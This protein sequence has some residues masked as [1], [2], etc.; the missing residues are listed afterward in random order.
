MKY[1]A[2]RK[3]TLFTY[4]LFCILGVNELFSQETIQITQKKDSLFFSV[5]NKLILKASVS[6]NASKLQ[7]RE[8]HYVLNNAVYQTISL[9]PMDFKRFTFKANITAEEGSIA[10]EGERWNDGISIVRHTVGKSFNLLNNSV[11]NRDQDWLLSFDAAY[12][13]MKLQPLENDQYQI[14]ME[15]SELIIRFK[16]KY[17]QQHRGLAYFKPKEYQIWKKPVVGWC[18][19]FAYFDNVTETDMHRTAD[20][21]STKLKKYGLDYI[22]IDDG[23]QQV[24]IGMPDTWINANKKFPAGMGNLANYIASKGFKPGIWTNVSFADSA[25]AYQHKELFIKTSKNEIALGNWVGYVMNGANKATIDQ[26]IK[27]VYAEFNNEGWQYFK[28]DALR[29]LKYEGYN[30]FSKD[31]I[32][33]GINKNEA[34]R[35]VVK[36]VRNQIGKEKFLMACWGIRPELVGLVDGCRIG[37]DGYSYAGLAQFN[38]YNNI[39]WR[40]DPDHIVLSAKEAYRSCTA[41]SLTGSLFML[42]DKPELYEK[43]NLIDAAIRSIPVLITRPGQVYDIDPSRSSLITQVET[44][45]SGSGPRPFDASS[46]TTTDLFQMDINKPYENWTILGRLDERDRVIPLKDLGLDTKKEYLVFE[47]WSKEFKGIQIKQFVPG[48]IDS[49]FNC[50]VF[51]FREKQNHPQL[52]ATNRHISCGALELKQLQWTNNRLTGSSD[53]VE[54]DLYTIYVYEPDGAQFK[55]IKTGSAQLIENNKSGNIRKISF[56]STEAAAIQWAIYYQ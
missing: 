13:A 35:N 49:A 40:N 19:W 25:A 23:Y 54:N 29:H 37:N 50:Q 43:S 7:I 14:Q 46:T 27:P 9:V 17:Y 30:A 32:R 39:I 3:T 24:P 26:L 10:C 38:S 15:K 52:L 33:D 22:Q 12:P 48:A 28:L 4:F 53:L 2:L 1:Q 47:F 5:Q 51:C 21:L 31:L 16:P 56:Q 20:V 34:Y 44:E 45:M 36:E 55:E 18:S 6:G 8:H 41:T 11:Y 42:T